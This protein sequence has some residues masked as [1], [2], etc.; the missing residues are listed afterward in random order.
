LGLRVYHCTE[1]EF[2]DQVDP[3]VY[4]AQ[5]GMM[6]MVLSVDEIVAEMKS[7]RDQFCKFK[8]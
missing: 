1:Q 8:D 7:M 3:A 6:E 5:V 2:K 4:D